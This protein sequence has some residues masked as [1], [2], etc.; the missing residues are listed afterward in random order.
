M[1]VHCPKCGYT[2]DYKGKRQAV[3]CP[4]CMYKFKITVQEQ[5]QKGIDR[6]MK[7][8]DNGVII[9][10]VSEKDVNRIKQKELWEKAGAEVVESS[11]DDRAVAVEIPDE[12][13]DE[14][15]KKFGELLEQKGKT[16][17]AENGNGTE[18]SDGS[19]E[20]AREINVRRS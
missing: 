6:R 2:W 17:T 8:L 4:N 14:V 16:E 18:K 13:A 1:L 12:K 5:E 3:T 10:T 15:L 19:G 7:D 9:F 20:K 11:K